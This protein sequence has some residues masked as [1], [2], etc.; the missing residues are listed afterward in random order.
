MSELGDLGDGFAD[1]G[2]VAFERLSEEKDD[3]SR[4]GDS[5]HGGAEIKAG[6]V[7]ICDGRKTVDGRV[8]DG[9]VRLGKLSVNGGLRS[10]QNAQNNHT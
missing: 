10:A 2:V 8:I 9:T 7:I 3:A 6:S 1:G 4:D 5:Q